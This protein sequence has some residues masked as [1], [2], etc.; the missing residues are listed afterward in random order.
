MV[1]KKIRNTHGPE[2]YI[3]KK[4][5][6]FLRERGWF[7]KEVVSGAFFMGMPD[8]YI[9]KRTYGS[10][11]VEIKNPTGYRF[12]A[13]QMEVF[14]R[15][16]SEGIGIW[17]LTAATEEEYAKLFKQANWWQFLHIPNVNQ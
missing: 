17:I 11:W 3:Q 4:V 6:K 5:C 15:L 7:V 12:T 13:A 8:L 14:P 9:A 2:Y 1:S 16:A 10:R